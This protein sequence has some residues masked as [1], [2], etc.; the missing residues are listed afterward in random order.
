MN[1]ISIY[2]S[3]L[4]KFI[5]DNDI[6]IDTN[7]N[8]YIQPNN[9]FSLIELVFG[10]NYSNRYQE[11]IDVTNF[12][13]NLKDQNI[14]E[15]TILNSK[16]KIE[17]LTRGDI[18]FSSYIQRNKKIISNNMKKTIV[19][20]LN[21]KSSTDTDLIFTTDKIYL[22]GSYLSFNKHIKACESYKNILPNKAGDSILIGKYSFENKK[23]NISELFKIIKLFAILSNDSNNNIYS[24]ANEIK[25]IIAD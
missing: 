21:D 1:D 9:E 17:F 2:E 25:N 10:D 23:V 7:N 16:D 20:I 14:N 4:N 13:S 3:L 8:T 5:I 11:D 24:L 15:N 12:I 19:A 6:R 22:I 18:Q